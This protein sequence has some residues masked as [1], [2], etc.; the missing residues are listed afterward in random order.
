MN[1]WSVTSFHNDVIYATYQEMIAKLGEPTIDGSGD[2]KVQKEW[3]FV[4]DNG[5]A[6]TIYD[7]KYYDTDVT[8][9][10]VIQW[11]IGHIGGLMKLQ[12]ISEWLNDKGLNVV[13]KSYNFLN[14]FNF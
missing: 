13:K 5:I 1:H 2:D 14:M 7:W 6:F 4:T 3:R 10:D 11:N 12:S 9:G 8:N